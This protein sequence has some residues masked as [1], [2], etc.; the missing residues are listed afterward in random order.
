MS[1]KA[2]A[3]LI[4]VPKLPFVDPGPLTPKAG[5]V[6]TTRGD[7]SGGYDVVITDKY[8][9]VTHYYYTD[10]KDAQTWAN[11]Y[12][13]G[14]YSVQDGSLKSVDVIPLGKASTAK[15]AVAN[16]DSA[17]RARIT[18]NEQAS[19]TSGS[20]TTSMSTGSAGGIFSVA[21][22]KKIAEVAR[23]KF[24]TAYKIPPDGFP[25]N[26]DCSLFTQWAYSQAGIKLPRTASEQYKAS[27]MGTNAVG[28]LI[29]FATNNS[30]PTE[31]THVGINLGGGK[32]IHASSGNGKVIIVS[33]ETPYW[34]QRLLG[35]GAP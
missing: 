15:A 20:G 25:K 10:P 26:T 7:G 30:E 19:R 12:R 4:T 8:G 11:W 22:G 3:S 24:Y 2:A 23:D 33:Y 14:P 27:K 5:G 28:S 17:S 29:F 31:A 9:K 1:P 6:A 32:M 34:Q 13:T 18:F 16:S 35:M 21:Q